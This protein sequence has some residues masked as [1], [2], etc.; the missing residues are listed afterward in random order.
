VRLDLPRGFENLK[1]CD[2]IPASH[3][4][5]RTQH[6][7]MRMR[8]SFISLMVVIMVVWVTAHHHD[9]A[10]ADAMFVDVSTQRE[11]VEVLLSKKAEME[12]E[13]QSLADRELLIRRLEEHVNIVVLTSDISKRMPET[14]V[15]TKLN[16]RAPGL[17]QFGVNETALKSVE[18]V[19]DP[20]S[21]GAAPAAPTPPAIVAPA[22]LELTGVANESSEIIRFAAALERSPLISRVSMQVKGQLDWSGKRTEQFEMTCELIEQVRARP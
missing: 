10:S 16:L 8:A 5:R 21:A 2:F 20:R 18:P 3:H 7:M 1:D 14:V 17:S 12:K 9:L 19:K 15:L 6:N 4:V 13:R 22:I 11:Q